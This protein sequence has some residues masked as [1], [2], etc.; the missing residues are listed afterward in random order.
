MEREVRKLET[1]EN[2]RVYAGRLKRGEL[3][4]YGVSL[5]KGDELNL[6][7]DHEGDVFLKILLKSTIIKTQNFK[8]KSQGNVLI[9]AKKTGWYQLTFD[10]IYGAAYSMNVLI[11]KKKEK[12]MRKTLKILKIGDLFKLLSFMVFP[13]AFGI[14]IFK[15]FWLLFIIPF[16]L[17]YY[18][19][20]EVSERKK[21][22]EYL[23]VFLSFISFL[24]TMS[25]LTFFVLSKEE[26]IVKVLVWVLGFVF[27]LFLYLIYVLIERVS[28]RKGESHSK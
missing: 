28:K 9:K 25:Y 22:L 6:E 2:E 23:L 14:L 27:Y 7:I 20:Y 12:E 16:T 21:V 17:L 26:L 15:F 10:S 13:L 18:Y 11:R 24:L 4:C 19:L 5:E 1:L 8:G 3:D